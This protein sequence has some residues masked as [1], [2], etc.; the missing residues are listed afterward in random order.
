[1]SL[2]FDMSVVS[3]E[4]YTVYCFNIPTILPNLWCQFDLIYNQLRNMS[5]D[6]LSEYFSDGTREE[7]LPEWTTPSSGPNIKRLGKIIVHQPSHIIGNCHYL[8]VSNAFAIFAWYKNPA[9]LDFRHWLKI[10]NLCGQ[11]GDNETLK[12]VDR[13]FSFF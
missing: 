10:K 7:K 5:I 12:Q 11:K 2:S 1:M 3:I 6:S 9:F 13:A 8:L 4:N